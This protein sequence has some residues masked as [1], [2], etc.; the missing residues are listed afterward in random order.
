MERFPNLFSFI[1]SGM[2]LLLIKTIYSNKWFAVGL[3]TDG[4][5]LKW[6]QHTVRHQEAPC[7]NFDCPTLEPFEQ[8]R[9]FKWGLV[10]DK[11]T[12]I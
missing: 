8:C 7:S 1:N 4:S 6:P 3:G 10:T 12:L 9:T 2:L 11:K 5:T